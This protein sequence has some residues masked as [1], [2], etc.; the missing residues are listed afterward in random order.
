MKTCC[1]FCRQ[2]QS[3]E[4]ADL[5][6]YGSC[7]L[8]ASLLAD[9][10]SG[11]KMPEMWS[12]SV[13]LWGTIVKALNAD[14]DIARQ[15]AK[16]PTRNKLVNRIVALR[17]LRSW[18]ELLRFRLKTCNPVKLER[19]KLSKSVKVR[20]GNFWSNTRNT[21]W[22]KHQKNV[23]TP[24]KPCAH[25]LICSRKNAGIN[26]V[27]DWLCFRPDL[28]KSLLPTDCVCVRHG[29][30]QT[31]HSLTWLSHCRL[32]CSTSAY[33]CACQAIVS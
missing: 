3:Q 23:K 27:P 6:S 17:I 5:G 12:I 19:R 7:K 4:P 11:R 10:S 25:I 2:I 14:H 26:W 29:F 18:H 24:Q 21:H 28:H 20:D 15:S 1:N 31:Q 22:L 30:L 9:K 32:N 13:G 8:R 33:C 16:N